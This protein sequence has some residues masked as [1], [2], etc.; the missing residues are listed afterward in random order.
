MFL[1]GSGKGGK[2]PKEAP[3]TLFSNQ[4]AHVLDLL[5]EG[6]I[7]GLVGDTEEERKRSIFYNEVPLIDSAGSPN[8]EGVVIYGTNG[9]PEQAPFP[10][11]S[12]ILSTIP[13]NQELPFDV[14]KTVSFPNDGSVTAVI[15]T[16]STG[17]F[18]EVEKDG[19]QVGTSVTFVIEISENGGP[20][21][22]AHSGNITGKQIDGFDR[23]YRID[24]G[25]PNGITAI[26]VKRT[27]PDA[28]S[29]KVNDGIKFSNYTRVVE[30]TLYY[31]NLALVGHVIDAKQF[32]NQI[33]TRQYR[34]RGIKC[35][36]PHNYDP[37][38]RTY[39]GP[40][41]GSLTEEKHYTNCGPWVLY[42]LVTNKRYGLGQFVQPDFLDIPTLYQAGVFA[43]EMVSDGKGG[44]EPRWVCNTV[45]NTRGEAF[46][47]LRELVSNF[48]AS[49]F[50]MQAR[51]WVVGDQ[52]RTPVKLVTNANVI[53]G[54][55]TRTGE[56]DSQRVSVVNV[57]WNDPDL[58][59]RR[60]IESVEEPSLIRE[61]GYKTKDFGAFGCSSRAQARRMGRAI[62]F[63]QEFES[64]MITYQASYDHM[65]VD[66]DGALGLAPGDTIIV[67]DR[68]S[69]NAV[70]G[71][72]V[73]AVNGSE[74]TVS[75]SPGPVPATDLDN[76]L[77]YK[78]SLLTLGGEP[79]T[80]GEFISGTGIIWIEH[81][82][83]GAIEYLEC[84]YSGQTVTLLETPVQPVAPNDQYVIL[85]NGAAPET[86]VVLKI[87]E[88]GENLLTVS[89]VKWDEARYAYIYEDGGLLETTNYMSLA[90]SSVTAPPPSIALTQRFVTGI[91]EYQRIIDIRAG[92]SPDPYLD[93]Y[94][95][96]YSYQNSEWV[97][98]PPSGSP[99]FSIR[100]AK[101][102][103]Y[104]VQSFAV[105]RNGVYS[106]VIEDTIT[107]PVAPPDDALA[108]GQITDLQ[109]QQG[110]SVFT[111]RDVK[112]T[113]S[114]VTP[115]STFASEAGLSGS[116][117]SKGIADPMF[118][119]CLV[120]VFAVDGETTTLL[121]EE[122]VID[123]NYVYSYEKNFEDTEGSPSRELMFSVVYRD[124]Y[125]RLSPASVITVSNP[126]PEFINAP[127]V[128]GYVG[129]LRVTYL[130]PNDTDF[131]GVR[132][133]AATVTEGVA[134]AEDDL[135]YDGPNTVIDLVDLPA[136]VH[137]VIV[138][139]YD[140]FGPGVPTDVLATTPLDIAAIERK[141]EPQFPTLEIR[142]FA[143]GNATG[144][145]RYA[146]H[147]VVR[148]GVSLSGGTWSLQSVIM[149]GATLSINAAN[150]L[151]ALSNVTRSGSFVVVYTHTDGVATDLLINVTFL[152]G[153]GAVRMLEASPS[154]PTWFEG[155]TSS[156]SVAMVALEGSTGLTGGTWS[157]VPDPE[158]T[159]TIDPNTGL[160]T[161][162]N[163]S[164][165]GVMLVTYTHTDAQETSLY[166]DVIYF[167][168]FYGRR[169]F[170]PN[171]NI[172]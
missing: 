11:F 156:R 27:K 90:S 7:E 49:L 17:A 150:G 167:P 5:S 22:V 95:A 21:E 84:T 40:F 130:P 70:S 102:G 60:A 61:I 86:Y 151:V 157:I 42:E 92:K 26:R 170:D 166:V 143:A 50:W 137:E 55:F 131:R 16:I 111:G 103:N 29:L 171:Y 78:F 110:G 54:R 35:R 106:S 18:F 14:Y 74:L 45:I 10:G 64:D 81:A 132:V 89:A 153:L 139:P 124:R 73:L 104:R 159:A 56:S 24:I 8:F 69:G 161:I 142:E 12:D 172:P 162:S 33:P 122:S 101:P 145:T 34:V 87:S 39:T 129:G 51:L 116:E 117:N 105:N 19:D 135:V 118:Q 15:V 1:T 63:S 72:R 83:N 71:G 76:A 57:S 37:V 128:F 160:I 141:I 47:V 94:M 91:D 144:T 38:T 108:L 147:N 98:L 99:S 67:S 97:T 163:A 25:D 96:R 85:Q 53:G 138:V 168:E 148:G 93:H 77:S 59:F 2:T 114:L 152:T 125:A 36:I 136:Q 169:P 30:H 164:D 134:V 52:P 126:P 79:L 75:S 43:D 48:R 65:A 28:N 68:R 119:D 158:I 66:G 20:F 3:D 58:F 32:G 44:L 165:T 123:T 9:T 100:G 82:S 154:V 107:L 80:V 120:S 4:T 149:G 46:A 88:E 133:Y 23:D 41:N 127:S 6:E 121:R 112:I 155:S 109:L 13:V 140:A 115:Q 113:W 31:P 62:L 146:A